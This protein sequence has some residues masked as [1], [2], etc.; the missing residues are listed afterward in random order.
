MVHIKN[1]VSYDK[2]GWKYISVK[3]KPKERGFAHGYFAAKYFKEA[4]RVM[5]FLV[6]EN[7]GK[8]WDFFIEAG[9]TELKPTIIKHFPEYYEEMEGI[10]EGCNAGG[11]ETTVDEIITWNNNITLLDFWYPSSTA[12]SGGPKLGAEGGG[13]KDRC[14]AF[15]AN[16]DYTTDGKIVIAHNSFVEYMDGQF[17]NVILDITPNKGHRIIMQTAPCCIWSGTDVFITSKGIMG[18]ETTIGGFNA[19][20]N[21]YTIACRIRKAMQY[22]NTL[23]DYVN[24]LLKGNSGDYANAWL[25]ADIHTNEI[26]RFELGLKY[27]DVKRTKN[28]YFY[29]C[30]FPFS[31][32]I[33]NFECSNTGYCDVRRH[34]G[35]R[36]VRIPDLIEEHKGKINVE[37]AKK[38]IS[39]HYDVY[40]KKVNPCSRTICAHYDLDA[41]EFMSDPARPKPFQAHGVIDGAVMDTD[42]AKKMGFYMRWGNSCGMP[43]NAKEYCNEHRQWKHLEPYL[44]DRPTQPW[45]FFTITDNYSNHSVNHS[46]KHSG[47]TTNRKPRRMRT[48]S[49]TKRHRL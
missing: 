2:N 37:V 44:R 16:G 17:Y 19:Y 47:K 9:K 20:E 13:Q 32:E 23:D 29:G 4:Q 8:H 7:T 18:T 21:N 39:D 45:T 24:I 48:M 27:H 1:G 35:A 43:F 3:G 41:R 5:K 30:N 33:R 36:Q 14:S 34:Q 42:S 31:P 26:M 38:I 40:L 28:G 15:V 25:F 49:R 11:T 6:Y 22:G 12:S 46:V 10:A